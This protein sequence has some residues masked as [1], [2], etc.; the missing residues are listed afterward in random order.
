MKKDDILKA[1]RNENKNR[2]LAEVE[3]QY[4]SIRYAAIGVLILATIYFWLEIFINDKTDYGWYSIITFFATIAYGYL[5]IKT[6][7]RTRIVLAVIW[8]LCS[9]VFIYR[10]LK[11]IIG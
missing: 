10:T 5:G 4:K 1:S 11:G 3:I 8:L 2:D 7:N 9:V 6:K